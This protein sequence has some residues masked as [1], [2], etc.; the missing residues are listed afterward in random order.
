[1]FDFGRD[2]LGREL[3]DVAFPGFPDTD[4]VWR[5]PFVSK[6]F[7]P[8]RN[9]LR[10]LL[11]FLDQPLRKWCVK[12]LF[13]DLL[14]GRRRWQNDFLDSRL[15]ELSVQIKAPRWLGD[16]LGKLDL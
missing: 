1:D 14:L 15:Q 7:A 4:D 3:D 5:S 11:N 8:K 6:A 16:L 13:P 2:D 10:T 12:T 9:R